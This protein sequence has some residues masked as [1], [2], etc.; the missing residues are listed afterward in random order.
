MGAPA[1]SRRMAS[2]QSERLAI[3]PF[4]IVHRQEDRLLLRRGAQDF[5]YPRP[6][7]SGATLEAPGNRSAH[8]VS[9]PAKAATRAAGAATSPRAPSS[10]PRA[11]ARTPLQGSVLSASTDRTAAT[12]APSSRS[13]ASSSSSSRV[14]PVPASPPSRSRLRRTAGGTRPRRRANATAPAL[15]RQRQPGF[16]CL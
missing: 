8:S 15:F 3:H 12:A 2:R 4:R 5:P 7:G 6:S 9:S 14:L 1:R 10:P 11:S 16:Q 13:L